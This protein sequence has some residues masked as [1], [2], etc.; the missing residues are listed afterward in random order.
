[1]SHYYAVAVPLSCAC[2]AVWRSHS[3]H[4]TLTCFGCGAI[5]QGLR[6]SITSAILLLQVLQ[7]ISVSDNRQSQPLQTSNLLQDETGLL[8]SVY[9]LDEEAC[10]V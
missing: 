8:Q 6:F 4:S 1:M 10:S 9:Q 3:A 5:N 2:H 7:T